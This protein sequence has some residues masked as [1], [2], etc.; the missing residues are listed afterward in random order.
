MRKKV[1]SI[2]LRQITGQLLSNCDIVV[3]WKSDGNL[4]K[5]AYIAQKWWC[6]YID[7][8]IFDIGMLY[9]FSHIPN[10]Y[11]DLSYWTWVIWLF[12]G[13]FEDSADISAIP[14]AFYSKAERTNLKISQLSH[15]LKDSIGKKKAHCSWIHILC[16]L[17]LR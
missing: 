6:L 16:S 11:S 1:D 9:E 14:G 10:G 13:Y 3:Q 5:T 12:Y 2:L 8:N 15:W 7:S 17:N 4:W